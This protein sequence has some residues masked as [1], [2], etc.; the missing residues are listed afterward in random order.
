MRLLVAE[1]AANA[2]VAEALAIARVRQY[3]AEQSMAAADPTIEERL[4][5]YRFEPTR[6]I[7]EQLGWEP[8]GG[9]DGEPGQLEV[10]RAYALALR[11]QIERREFEAGTLPESALTCWTPDTQIQNRIRIEAGYTVG[12]T[13]LA[14]GMVNHFFDCFPPAIVYCFA[15]GREQIH[16]LLFKEI[17]ADRTGKGLPGRILDLALDRGPDHFAKGRATNNTEGKGRERIQ[18]QHGPYLMFVLDEAEAIDEYVWDG[19]ESMTSGGLSIVLM[20]ANP[21]TLT[22]RFH[23][24]AA[25]ANTVSFRISELAHP[26]VREGRDVITGAVRRE[27][28]N[29][30]IDDH[31][32]EVLEADLDNYTFSVPWRPGIF[33][34]DAEFLFSVLGVAPTNVADN[35]IVPLGRYETACKRPSTEDRPDVAR[36][37]LDVALF[38]RDMGTLYLRHNGSVRRLEQFAQQDYYHQALRIK[39]HARALVDQGVTSLH[40]RVDAGG[41]F[42]RGV[43]DQIKYDA[44]FTALFPDLQLVEINFG[45]PPRDT[46]AYANVVTELYF[47]VA[48]SLK[49][50]S[51]VNA[52]T[53]LASDLCERIYDWTNVSGV[54]VKRLEV[55]DNYRKRMRRSPDDGDGFVLAV[56]A[57]HLVEKRQI[58]A[59]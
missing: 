33:R 39:A 5:P 55:K 52:P 48:E 31:A 7:S 32:T 25:A 54:A 18:G 36:M 37:G 17:K 12:K 50:I 45:S 4:P 53:T 1:S 58:R 21:R 38:G 46:K 51:V 27:F 47:D 24:A 2:V 34:P 23:K 11:Q 20:L 15:P 6:Y 9:A 57:D 22:S 13:K 49:G 16:D 43:I 41:G 19:V 44:E 10:L 29:G 30:M 59:Y 3:A 26:N 40:I 14:S 35:T 28:V 8:W 42:G 56:A